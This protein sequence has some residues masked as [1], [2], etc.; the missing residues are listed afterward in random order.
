MIIVIVKVTTGNLSYCQLNT[1]VL[2]F[3]NEIYTEIV[4]QQF[5]EF[6]METNTLKKYL[7]TNMHT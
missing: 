6:I 4:K 2:G 3:F 7:H 1:E 5:N